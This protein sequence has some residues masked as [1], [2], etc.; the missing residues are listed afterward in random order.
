MTPDKTVIQQ[1]VRNHI[2]E[3]L[4]WSG[5]KKVV[6]LCLHSSY[7]MQNSFHFDKFFPLIITKF[8]PWLS[9]KKLWKKSW[10]FVYIPE[11]WRR[12]KKSTHLSF[13]FYSVEKK[14]VQTR[15]RFF[16]PLCLQ[17]QLLSRVFFGCYNFAADCWVNEAPPVQLSWACLQVGLVSVL[18]T[19]DNKHEK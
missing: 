10:N 13:L 15:L 17:N 9:K 4:V 8:Y 7:S 14:R 11:F 16:K 18:L 5:E 2:W 6:K 1:G 12:I 3:I 19:A